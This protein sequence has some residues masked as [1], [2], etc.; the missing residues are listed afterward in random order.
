MMLVPDAAQC[1]IYNNNRFVVKVG[2]GSNGVN[3]V[4]FGFMF[5]S[6]YIKWAQKS[7][8]R[9]VMFV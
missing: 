7:Y 9:V 8:L 4:D 5:V 6:Y 3:I 1:D 2:G